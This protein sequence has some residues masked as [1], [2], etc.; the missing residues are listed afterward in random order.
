VWS[1]EERGLVSHKYLEDKSMQDILTGLL[2]NIIWF[3]LGIMVANYV[4]CK[5]NF[6]TFAKIFPQAPV[7][8][9]YVNPSNFSSKI[10]YV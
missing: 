10:S 3:A 7:V 1:D 4:F 8:K 9:F 6:L 2:T 5:R